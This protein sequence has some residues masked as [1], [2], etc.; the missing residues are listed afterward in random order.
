M[1][2]DRTH[3]PSPLP[4]A[5]EPGPA[6]RSDLWAA[7][8]VLLPH[9]DGRLLVV[10]LTYDSDQP[11]GLPGGGV[12]H[13]ESPRQAAAREAREELGID[14]EL[15]PLACIDW[16]TNPYHP[17]V[18]AHLYWARPVTGDQIAA[19]RPQESEIAG[20]GLLTAA[21]ACAAVPSALS[22]RVAA[23][24]AAGPGS[25]PVELENGRPHGLP[26]GSQH[27][28][29]AEDPTARQ[30]AQNLVSDS[31]VRHP[32]PL[33]PAAYAAS[34]SRIVASARQLLTTS[35]GRVLLARVVGPD[36]YW[37]LPGG[38]V[39]AEH[40]S[41]RQAVRREIAEE[42]GWDRTPGRFLA[43]DWSDNGTQARLAFIFDGGT[44][45]E[46]DIARIRRQE[47]EIAEVR[48]C[49]TRQAE[50]LLPPHSM[51]RLRACLDARARGTGPAELH[52]GYPAP[53]S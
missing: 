7:G 26:S 38:K 8:G 9:I 43:L 28:G 42:L 12:E 29:A 18:A 27:H 19:I 32:L 36:R 4:A 25:A 23:C 20:I 33:T 37:L 14:V 1:T 15:G 13:G 53:A 30:Q 2:T 40:E 44:V 5:P 17:P 41:P 35:D 48:L 16:V 34:R 21:Q 24:L 47:E 11:I 52:D 46:A 49:T 39:E 45:T 10:R 31:G 3:L 50:D 6:R 51:A 22:R